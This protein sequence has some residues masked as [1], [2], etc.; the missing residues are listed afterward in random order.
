MDNP[1]ALVRLL[2]LTSPSLP[3]GGFTYSQGLEWAVE[4]GWVGDEASLAGWLRE[5][6]LEQLARVDLPLLERL[7][8]AAARADRAAFDHWNHELIACRESAELRAEER[9][10]GRA[11]ALLVL[12]LIPTA[13]AWREPLR[14]SQLGGFALAA[15]HWQIPLPELL[16]GYAWSWLENLVLAG[17][18]LVPLGQSAGQRLL[19]RLGGELPRA[20]AEAQ[21]LPDEEIGASAPAAAIASAL[22]EGQ[23]TRLFRS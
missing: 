22:H 15:A 9:A 6:L 19:L 7:Y 14:A 3:V 18:K 17:V 1:T 4:A 16:T 23:Y 20:V 21:A 11:M 5:L 8:Q 2:Q 12:E 13:A 10:R